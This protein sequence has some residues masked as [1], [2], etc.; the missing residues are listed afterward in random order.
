MGREQDSR[1]R[2]VCR[3]P[4]GGASGAGVIDAELGGW[5]WLQPKG[6]SGGSREA[7]PASH[8]FPRGVGRGRLRCYSEA[9]Q[10]L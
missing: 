10:L 7:A 4:L 6:A 8:V 9:R 2:R 5:R 3:W 1:R